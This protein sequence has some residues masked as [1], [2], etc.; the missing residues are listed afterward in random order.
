MTEAE[1]SNDSARLQQAILHSPAKEIISPL[2]DAVAL[3]EVAALRGLD[4][5]ALQFD[6]FG[7]K[8]EGG[9]LRRGIDAQRVVHIPQKGGHKQFAA[10]HAMEPEGAPAVGRGPNRRPGPVDRG[11]GEGTALGIAHLAPEFLRTQRSAHA[12]GEQSDC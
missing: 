12:E 9:L 1:F 10:L 8:P 5:D 2:D 4:H 6:P 3:D 11:S 7:T